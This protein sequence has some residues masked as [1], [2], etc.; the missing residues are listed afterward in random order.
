MRRSARDLLG[1]LQQLATTAPPPAEPR[2]CPGD[3]YRDLVAL[4]A[5]HAG[6][7]IDREQKTV[8]VTTERIVLDG[9]DLGPFVI[10]W[11]W[12]RLGEEDELRV[13]AQE[14]H[15]PGDRDDITHPHVRDQSLCAGRAELSL[16]RAWR[17]GRLFDAFLIV[18]QILQTYNP[19]SAYVTLDDWSSYRC[20]ACG[21]SVSDEDHDHCETCDLDLCGGC[22]RSCHQCGAASC[23]ACV[24]TCSECDETVC[25][26]C[27]PLVDGRRLKLCPACYE[28]TTNDANET[29]DPAAE[30]TNP[31]TILTL[32]SDG[33]GSAAVSA[34][35]GTDGDR[36]LRDQPGT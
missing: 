25:P 15:S 27:R 9:V 36:G 13:I 28:E 8:A 30:V 3:L 33:V 7:A 32:Q 24:V 23:S 6:V 10:E 2:A 17:A 19:D 18:R 12:G 31:G 22:V 4:S 16:Q 14:P 11:S 35:C 29:L 26:R 21:D 34:G 1:D 20:E 5:E